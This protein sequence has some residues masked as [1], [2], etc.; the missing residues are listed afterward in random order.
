LGRS[1]K[2]GF[3]IRKCFDFEVQVI[4]ENAFNELV[5]NWTD[6]RARAKQRRR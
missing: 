4:A 3:L 5:A 1:F 2:I 6:I